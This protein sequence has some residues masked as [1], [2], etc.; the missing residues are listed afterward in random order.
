MKARVLQ[1]NLQDMLDAVGCAIPGKSTLEILTHVVLQAGDGFLEAVGTDLAKGARVRRP[2]KVEAEGAVAVPYKTLRDL[3]RR[4][5]KEVI[6]LELDESTLSLAVRCANHKATVKGLDAS[7]APPVPSK[8]DGQKVTVDSATFLDT[9]RQVAVAA[10]K[11]EVRPVLTGVHLLCGMDGLLMEAADGYRLARAERSESAA[12]TCEVLVPVDSM[13]AV[14]SLINGKGDT[15]EIEFDEE[16]V[17]F[18]LFDAVLV[19][20][21]IAGD[22]PDVTS[23]IPDQWN[24]TALVDTEQF[25][26][27]LRATMVFGRDSDYVT[28]LRLSEGE[29][30][31]SATSA[32]RGECSVPVPTKDQEGDPMTVLVS[33]RYLVEAVLT[34][35][36]PEAVIRLVS[37][38]RPLMVAPV[39]EERLTHIIMPIHK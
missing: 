39:G 21:L 1:N 19:A 36:T 30:V 14:R 16:K 6:D 26:D 10:S 33:S 25:R 29:L 37:P 31:L 24:T 22:Y 9:V 35:N 4:L 7:D 27:A 8:L 17:L 15:V 2:A 28:T 20:Q 38:N 13:R 5:P 11:D 23:V 34:L 3:V 32:E 18:R 12:R